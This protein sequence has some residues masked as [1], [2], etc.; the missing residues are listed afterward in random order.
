MAGRHAYHRGVAAEQKRSYAIVGTGALGGFYGAMLARAGH[1]VHF[2]LRSDYHHVRRHGL[3]VKSNRHGDLS[4]ADPNVYDRAHALPRCDVVAVCLKT[5]ENGS[6]GDLLP[7]AAADDATVL[8]MQNG[9]GNEA[10]A[11]SAVPDRTIVGGL[12]FLCSNKTGPGRIHHL[13]YGAVRLGEHTSDGR[14][15]GATDIVRGI[16]ADFRAA[17]VHT[18][19]EEDLVTARWM[20][21][22]WNVPFNGLCALH[23][24]TTDVIMSTANTRDRAEALMRE[25]VAAADACGKKIDESFIDFMLKS[26]DEMVA[27]KPSMLLDAERG[28]RLE[29]EAIYDAPIAA[30]RAAGA[31]CPEMESLASELRARDTDR[32]VDRG[33]DA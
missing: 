12:A 25:V 6:L 14:P 20:K 32:V 33:G 4:I 1:D 30:A 10:L 16:A 11:A 5:T 9:L 7:A 26:T 8:M 29:I 13:D 2:L 31:S 18:D 15:A 23:G 19:V 22:V 27:Y 17:G 21:L 24:V 3:D 28:A